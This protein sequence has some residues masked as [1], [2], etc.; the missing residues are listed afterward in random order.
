MRAL[1]LCSACFA[2]MAQS[3]AATT[4]TA[5][6]SPGPLVL[7][8]PATTTLHFSQASPSL[9]AVP[10]F[11][12]VDAT[13]SGHGWHLTASVRTTGGWLAL[14]SFALRLLQPQGSPGDDPRRI[15]SSVPLGANAVT[16]AYAARNTGMGTFT[17]RFAAV[18]A[19]SGLFMPTHVSLR[20][21]LVSGAA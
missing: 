11:T 17:Y 18:T 12:V 13:G 16:V 1:L 15:S 2:A 14:G 3:A 5:T 19:P 20:L 6:I 9:A 10:T 8:G 21:R 7:R 4:A